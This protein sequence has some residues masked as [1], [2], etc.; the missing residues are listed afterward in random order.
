MLCKVV[1]SQ[2]GV[3]FIMQWSER[4]VI[5]EACLG[6]HLHR[7]RMG[8]QFHRLLVHSPLQCIGLFQ[9]EDLCFLIKWEHATCA[10]RELAERHD[11]SGY[12]LFGFF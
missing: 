4:R 12:Q 6:L 9:N 8:V 5:D 10:K 3:I 7:T 2:K 1:Q 11:T